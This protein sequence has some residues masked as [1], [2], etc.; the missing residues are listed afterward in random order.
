MYRCPL[1]KPLCLFP[2]GALSKAVAPKEGSCYSLPEIEKTMSGT[3]GR[4]SYHPCM[5]HIHIY[6]HLVDFY[7]K[8]G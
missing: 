5:I 1:T 3:N 8:C 6:L 4:K 2:P 7:G